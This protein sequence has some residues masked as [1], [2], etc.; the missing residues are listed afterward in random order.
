MASSAAV[1]AASR[2]WSWAAESACSAAWACAT[3]ACS[4]A[5]RCSKVATKPPSDCC[6]LAAWAWLLW[7]CWASAVAQTSATLF[8]L[9]PK[10]ADRPS[11]WVCT[12]STMRAWKAALSRATPASVASTTGTIMAP[13]S[14]ALSVRLSLSERSTD[15]ASAA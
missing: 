8:T 5:A 9:L 13:A 14:R 2:C 12:V 3:V 15:V 11:N 7:P 1:H 10:R 6:R 4:A